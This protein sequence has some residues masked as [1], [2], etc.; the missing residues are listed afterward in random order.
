[1]RLERRLEKL[2][3]APAY[4]LYGPRVLYRW[5]ACLQWAKSRLSAPVHN[6]SELISRSKATQSTSSIAEAQHHE[7][8]LRSAEP[9]P[10]RGRS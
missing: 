3:S 5:G 8:E 2:V 10:G 1:M 7:A 9:K 4:Q 6:T